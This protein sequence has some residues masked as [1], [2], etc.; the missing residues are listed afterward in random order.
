MFRRTRA[1]SITKLIISLAKTDRKASLV[2]GRAKM[3]KIRGVGRVGIKATSPAKAKVSREDF[4]GRV[5]AFRVDSLDKVVNKDLDSSRIRVGNDRVMNEEV[6]SP[7]G[8]IQEDLVVAL[9]VL[10]RN[11]SLL[12]NQEI[13]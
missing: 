13:L 7:A 5:R 12:S 1:F 4:L 11:V 10:V 3:A 6:V 2:R 9:P 8:R